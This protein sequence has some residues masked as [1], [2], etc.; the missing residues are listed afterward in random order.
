MRP[1]VYVACLLLVAP[2]VLFTVLHDA[3]MAVIA[4]DTLGQLLGA[5]W[6]GLSKRRPMFDAIPMW[7]MYVLMALVPVSLIAFVALAWSA[8]HAWIGFGLIALVGLCLT[9]LVFV[10]DGAPPSLPIA[11]LHVPAILGVS[12]A[13]WALAHDPRVAELRSGWSQTSER[14]GAP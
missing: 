9:V 10:R 11:L 14:G 1:L 12:I 6:R 13:A 4:S 8:R 5:F 2:V 3:I 7:G